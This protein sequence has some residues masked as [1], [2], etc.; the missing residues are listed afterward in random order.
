[1]HIRVCRTHR[2]GN[3]YEYAQLVESFRRADGMPA[4][5][6][7][8]TLGR[9]D[10]VV[11]LNLRKALDAA[12]QGKRVAVGRQASLPRSTPAKP[13]ANLRYLDLAV[14]LDLWRE[15]RLPE[16][17]DEL[18]PAGDHD[19]SPAAVVAALALQRCVD[20]GSKLYATR[21]LP[22]TALPELLGIEPGQFNNTRLHRV[23]DEL[24][25]STTA[26]MAKLPRGYVER[27]GAFASLFL[28]VSD[29]WFAGEGPAIA[30]RAKT[31][32][33]MVARKIGILLLC[34]ERG[35]PLRWDVIEG[36]Q[37]DSVAMT[38]MLRSIAGVGWASQAPV[39][40]DRAMGK[41]AQIRQMLATGLHFLTALTVTEFDAYAP[42]LPHQAL[43]EL[44]PSEPASHE[45]DRD[46]AARCAEVA[47]MQ[48]VEDDLLVM[49]LGV[50]ERA[51]VVSRS[52]AV[53]ETQDETVEAM[54]RARALEEA[55]AQGRFASYAAAGR[56]LGLGK[57]LTH[58][59]HHL[60]RL[61]EQQQRDVLDGKAIGTIAELLIVTA[62]Q[63]PEQRAQAFDALVRRPPQSQRRRPRTCPTPTGPVAPEPPLRL[64]V[65]AYFN[66]DRFVHERR[67]AQAQLAELRSF[68]TELNANLSRPRSRQ[69]EHTI[70]AAV[71]RRLRQDSLLDA[72]AVR[73]RNQTHPQRAYWQVELLLDETEWA[74]RRRYDGFTVLVAHEQLP[75]NAVELCRLYRAKDAVEK[76]FQV[77]K[78]V[79][80][81]RPIRHQTESK[82]RAH[83]T[84]C[85]LALL[86]ERMLR[87]KLAGHAGSAEAAIETLA[88]CHLNLYAGEHEPAAYTIT[89]PDQDQRAILRVLRLR[90]LADDD[91]LAEKITPR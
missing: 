42:Q 15:A 79:V 47:G 29:A 57:S 32:E 69:T 80:Q 19:V 54:R 4:H 89:E 83:V 9:P 59:L 73:I 70:A 33:G 39:V 55:V 44:H 36:T 87:R 63:D 5:R 35:Y 52:I 6:V 8:A 82:V 1:M 25:Q 14:L 46:Q 12:R 10:D 85:M 84:I 48:R 20:P 16:L 53:A 62:M 86:L 38:G 26:L 61:S 23:L 67:Q 31:K 43:S 65:V 28:D 60:T 88:P 21:W 91:Y 11:V 71:D 37:N 72:F 7:I 50:V 41:T 22:R 64:R 45:R 24:D 18:M 2:N 34:N 27:E 81:L 3:T 77:I 49:D 78:S 51:D 13:T 68:V 58:K 74:R 30:K 40:C 66:P 17:L 90:H 76:D 56:S 75:H